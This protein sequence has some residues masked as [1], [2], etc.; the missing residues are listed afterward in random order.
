MPGFQTS[1][2]AL[3]YGD[4][5]R[6]VWWSSSRREPAMI[7]LSRRVGIAV[8]S[9]VAATLVVWLVGGVA[10]ALFGLNTAT[11]AGQGQLVGGIGLTVL[12]IVLGG[13]IYRDIMRREHDRS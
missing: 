6:I 9:F 1:R 8:G 7:R 2:L 11:A 3:D 13:L 12:A 10:F 4:P 5:V